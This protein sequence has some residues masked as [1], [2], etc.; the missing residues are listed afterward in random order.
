M[1]CVGLAA[2]GLII[3]LFA[4]PLSGGLV[5]TFDDL[6]RYHLPFRFFYAQSLKA[7]DSFI[8]L[9]NIFCGFYIHGEGQVGMYHPLH[10]LL[11]GILPLTTAFNIEL[12]LSFPFMAAGMY[13]FLRRWKIPRDAAMLGASVFTLSGFNLLHF[14]HMNATAVAAH[15]P[16]LLYAVDVAVGAG[17]ERRAAFAWLAVAL[18]TASQLLLGHPSIFWL[19]AVAEGFYAL[20]LILSRRSTARQLFRLALAKLLGVLIG[21]VQ[22]VPHWDVAASSVR[23]NPSLDFLQWPSVHPTQVAQLVAPYFFHSGFFEG[24]PYELK[25]YNG[26]MP[27]LL[28][29]LLF[30]RRKDLG[31]LRPLAAGAV[32][33]GVLSLVMALGKYGY[34]HWLQ[35][36]LPLVR[37]LRTP[38]RYVLLF[39]LALAI[40]AAVAFA[41]LSTLARRRERIAWRKL[42]PLALA[43]IASAAPP[44]FLFLADIGFQSAPARFF[45]SSATSM[46]LVIAGPAL[47]L[48]A[49]LV[50]IMTSR[51]M[52]YGLIGIILF[53]AVDLGAY[54]F[55]YI[56]R[57]PP[58]NFESLVDSRPTPPNALRY[59]LQSE[60]NVLLMKGIRLSDG[61]VSIPPKR[62]LEP[63]NQARLKVAGARWLWAK[64][65]QFSGG[66]A[67]GVQLPEPLPRVRL[68]SKALVSSDPNRDI[69]TIDV[70]STALVSR[71]IKLA[72]GPPGKAAIAGDRPGRIRIETEAGSRQLLVLSESY[73]DGWQVT[74]DGRKSSVLRIYGDFMG[75]IVDGGRHEVEFVFRPKSLQAG[76]LLSVIGLGLATA[77]FLVSIFWRKRND[78]VNSDAA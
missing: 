4:L 12:V 78:G 62:K 19:S 13:L 23:I 39:H 53:T 68:V 30:V 69:D 25:T 54:G 26:A 2:A 74:V 36:L 6:I 71:E 72:G 48:T 11:Y 17:K 45:A 20:L 27:L 75:C 41:D 43:P 50:L 61:Y 24:I 67:Y 16:W 55:S 38:C 31:R 35:T 33:L 21:C 51:G 60:D 5:Y 47:F 22:L 64:R 40:V 70:G 44:L 32:M 8:W 7:G 63:L 37:L 14:M 52:Q 65:P 34:L 18:L 28:L 10:L 29:A 77:F 76:A 15:I 1:F 73:H 66:R 9:P 58:R 56:W 3:F 46:E 57:F 59:R 49:L 42:W